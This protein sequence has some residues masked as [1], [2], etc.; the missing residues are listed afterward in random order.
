MSPRGLFR[1]AS[2][3]GR[4]STDP[5]ID[6]P[7]PLQTALRLGV[8]LLLGLL[9]G[10]EREYRGKEAGLKTMA[11]V[12]LGSAAFVLAGLQLLARS[13]QPGDATRLIA[14]LATAIGFLGAG[15]ILRR[16]KINPDRPHAYHVQGLTTAANI[17]VGCAVGSAAGAGLFWTAGLTTFFAAVVLIVGPQAERPV[18]KKSEWPN[19]DKPDHATQKKAKHSVK[20]KANAHSTD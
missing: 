20:K 2:S 1:P 3:P 13:G 7:D 12:S 15:V 4:P 8:A 11:L 6:N 19:H 5:V 16:H 9:L 14:G 10:L 17:F 18:R